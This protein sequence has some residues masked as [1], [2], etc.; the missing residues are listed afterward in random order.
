MAAGIRCGSTSPAAFGSCSCRDWAKGR[1]TST[2]FAITWVFEKADPYGFAAEVPPRTASKVAD[3]NRY[4][5][6]DGTG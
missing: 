2:R 3:L 5:W 1:S 4:A 6:H